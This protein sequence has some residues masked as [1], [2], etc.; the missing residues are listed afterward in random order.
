[1]FDVV[2]SFRENFGSIQFL[3]MEKLKRS[4]IDFEE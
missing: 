1:M 4:F 2:S 3:D